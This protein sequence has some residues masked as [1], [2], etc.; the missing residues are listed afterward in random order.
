MTRYGRSRLLSI[1]VLLVAL[2]RPALGA[3]ENS[4]PRDGTVQEKKPTNPAKNA[5]A[6]TATLQLERARE[7]ARGGKYDEAIADL[8]VIAAR[9]E[10]STDPMLLAVAA[11]AT[12]AKGS[13]LRQRGQN[14]EA[15]KLFDRVVERFGKA[16][17]LNQ[18]K[19]VVWSLIQKGEVLTEQSRS[20]E[21]LST[22]EDAITRTG[23]DADLAKE[24]AVARYDKGMELIRVGEN[25]RAIAALDQIVSSYG[26]ATTPDLQEP[27][28]LAL[29]AKAMAL[30]R[31][32]KKSE[33]I[34]AYD[35]AV[36][37]YGNSTDIAVRTAIAK[38]L[39]DK[40]NML[41]NGDDDQGAIV[42]SDEVIRRFGDAKEFQFKQWIA[43]AHYIRGF[44][45]L[46]LHRYPE[47]RASFAEIA[48]RF[49]DTQDPSIRDTVAV[50]QRTLRDLD[51]LESE[52]KPEAETTSQMPPP[53]PA[54]TP[55]MALSASPA[56]LA[57]SYLNAKQMLVVA[58]RVPEKFTVVTP[59]GP[60]NKDYAPRWKIVLQTREATYSQAIRKRATTSF[61]G[62]YRLSSE[63]ASCAKA[64]SYFAR[65]L[66][67]RQSKGG[68]LTIAQSG[69]ELKLSFGDT[70]FENPNAYA[71][72]NTFAFSDPMNMDYTHV[73]ELIGNKLVI[74][75][76][77][78]VLRTWPE[79][80]GPPKAE[81]IRNCSV[82]LVREK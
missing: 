31:V 5:A 22:Y 19:W 21:A 6:D 12:Y 34:S 54:L 51:Q 46:R 40:A 8:D 35:Y 39:V 79:F 52:A 65:T 63:S 57:K 49:G 16:S 3:L 30:E 14:E 4:P 13:V 45:L 36:S 44:A 72:E 77:A 32:G 70:S 15:V 26:S 69:F 55:E 60:I 56:D 37:H 23:I 9:Y 29:D 82:E 75:P 48:R 78:E 20:A 18:R 27:L 76:Q 58:D 50:A 38:T 73:G 2:S 62:V 59:E 7:L 42:G 11:R 41:A 67:D 1:V 10:N 80:A 53:A 25:D 33:A 61:A 24:A 47:A 66:A 28:V 71:V 43:K 64:N 17:E 68:R 81:D 74:R